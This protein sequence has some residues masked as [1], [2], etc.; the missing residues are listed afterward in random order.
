MLLALPYSALAA[1]I[2]TD[3]VAPSAITPISQTGLGNLNPITVP[4]APTGTNLD[5]AGVMPA[6]PNSS[7]VPD[8][9]AAL[10]ATPAAP[11]SN[12]AQWSVGLRAPAPGTSVVPDAQHQPAP[13]PYFVGSLTSLGVPKALAEELADYQ[14]SRHPG[15]QDKVYHGLGHSLDVPAVISRIIEDLPPDALSQR[16]KIMLVL[17]AA[18]HDIDPQRGRETPAR[19]SATL[20]YLELDP[21]SQKLLAEFERKYGITTAQVEALIKATDFNPDPAGQQKIQEDFEA[22]VKTAFPRNEQDWALR[23]GR[24]LSF[25]DKSAT[26]LG[27]VESADRQVVNLANE[28]RHGIEAANGK[29]SVNPTD[30]SM[31]QGSHAFLKVLR[32]SPDYALLP[33]ALQNNFQKVL[34]HFQAVADGRLPAAA[35]AAQAHTRAPPSQLAAPK[36]LVDVATDQELAKLN[37]AGFA[38]LAPG[39]LMDAQAEAKILEIVDRDWTRDGEPIFNAL[40]FDDPTQPTWKARMAS[41]NEAMGPVVAALTARLNKVLAGESIE[42]RDVQLRLSNPKKPERRGM[43]VD[44]G[45]YITATYALRGR[46]TVLFRMDNGKAQAREAPTHTWAI[47]TNMEREIVTGIQGIVHDTPVS[48]GERVLLIIRFRRAGQDLSSEERGAATQR[49]DTRLARYNESLAKQGKIEP[50]AKPGLL[51]SFKKIFGE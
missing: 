49:I 22:R 46:G 23:W 33:E 10:A 47:I 21:A 45:G 18:L 2:K 27:S 37:T 11:V 28:I 40:P 12:D 32:A 48:D 51:S 24:R 43:H 6:L 19:V 3:A 41:T 39:A 29:P 9:P 31:L 16:Q 5:P 42:V 8:Q 34:D 44:L 36:S 35:L 38:V 13:E 4:G 30:E 25:A 7:V 15:D 26:Y 17:A 14:S 20:T 50:I 1:D